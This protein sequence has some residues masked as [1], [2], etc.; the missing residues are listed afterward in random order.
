MMIL[1]NW[2]HSIFQ[3]HFIMGIIFNCFNVFHCFI[4]WPT[5]SA[6]LSQGPTVLHSTD[7]LIQAGLVVTALGRPETDEALQLILGSSWRLGANLARGSSKKRIVVERKMDGYTNDIQWCLYVY[8]YIYIYHDISTLVH[9]TFQLRWTTSTSN[10]C[11]PFFL[12]HCLSGRRLLDISCPCNPN[13]RPNQPWSICHSLER[14][15]TSQ[16]WRF[17]WTVGIPWCWM[18]PSPE[19]SFKNCNRPYT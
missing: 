8:I 11:R 2:D 10:C 1:W 6:L 16:L 14:P 12:G 17:H 4:V 15:K 3:T 19:L 9:L 13:P 18:Q 5:H 7:V